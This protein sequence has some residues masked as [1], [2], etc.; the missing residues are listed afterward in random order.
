MLELCM[1]YAYGEDSPWGI[2]PWRLQKKFICSVECIDINLVSMADL[3]LM[4]STA[5]WEKGYPEYH[6]LDLTGYERHGGIHWTLRRDLR[7]S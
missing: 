1:N 6:R 4:Y 5:D 7:I 2:P 3:G